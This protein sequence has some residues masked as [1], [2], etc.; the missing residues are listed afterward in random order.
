M[1]RQGY[2]A[3]GLE[4]ILAASGSPKGSFYFH[5]PEGKEQLAA[6]ALRA[7]GVGVRTF[8]DDVVAAATSPGDAVRRIAASE[9]RQLARSGFERGCPIATVTLEMASRSEPI[10]RAADEAFESWAAPL[11]AMLPAGGV[12][13]GEAATLRPMG[14]RRPRGRPR[15]RPRRTRRIARHQPRRDHRR[16]PR[17]PPLLTTTASARWPGG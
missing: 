1:Q 11:A 14:D 12:A 16:R 13:D 6:E 5:F 2:A 3:T 15:P 10:Q 17:R 9:A 8:I 7:G 4:A